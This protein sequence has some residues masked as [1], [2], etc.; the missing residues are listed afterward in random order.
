MSTKAGNPVKSAQ[1]PT[2]EG[3]VGAAY[4][5]G[6]PNR[7]VCCWQTTCLLGFRVPGE[8]LELEHLK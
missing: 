5:A 2:F 4:G 6:G 3:F 8:I 7:F 1:A